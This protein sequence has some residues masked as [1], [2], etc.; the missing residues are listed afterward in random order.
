MRVFPVWFL[1]SDHTP[2]TCSPACSVTELEFSDFVEFTTMLFHAAFNPVGI[3]EKSSNDIVFTECIDL[4][5]VFQTVEHTAENYLKK[6]I[7][8]LFCHAFFHT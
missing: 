1:S 6:Q 7:K 4:K 8:P 2:A 3:T 5:I